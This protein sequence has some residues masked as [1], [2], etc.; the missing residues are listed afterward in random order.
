MLII[1]LIPALSQV[2]TFHIVLHCNYTLCCITVPAQHLASLVS[3]VTERVSIQNVS[4]CDLVS[5]LDSVKSNVLNITRQNLDSE[6]TQALVQ[7][8]ETGV[9]IVRLY[10]EVTLDIRD[11]MEY[12]G[13][14]KCRGLEVYRED[15]AAR[16][17]E[18]LRTWAT[19]RNWE[20]TQD[21]EDCP[22]C[23]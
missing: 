4:G 20:V 16:Y 13:Q 17:K 23:F 14:G 22:D 8:M 1:I 12:S 7:A 6:E 19:S 9:K 2:T 21:D 5:V 18:Q 15:T 10:K 11:L 3:S